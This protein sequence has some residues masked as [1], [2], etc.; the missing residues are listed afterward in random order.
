MVDPSDKVSIRLIEKEDLRRIVYWL[1]KREVADALVL[2]RMVTYEDELIWFE[3]Y[4]QDD[5]KK[6]FAIEVNGCHV[7][8]ISLFNID[9][10]HRRALMSIFL[11]E[12][13]FRGKGIGSEA[14]R[15]LIAIAFYKLSLL[16]VG[17]ETLSDNLNAIRCY[18]KIGMKREGVQR[19]YVNLNGKQ[20]DM[21]LLSYIK[22]E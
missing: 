11:G 2:N 21:L 15:Q 8:N 10:F 3:N 20:R 22:N 7:G 9:W 12:E 18:E 14:I 16:R 19:S 6:V 17:V 13:E 4:L 1:N 5:K